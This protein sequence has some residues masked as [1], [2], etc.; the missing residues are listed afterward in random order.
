MKKQIAKFSLF[1]ICCISI[2]SACNSSQNQSQ[3]L[4][5]KSSIPAETP[6]MGWNSWNCFAF[7]TNEEVVKANADYMAKHLKEF[8]WKYIVVDMGWYYPLEMSTN[9]GHRV[10]PPHTID[11]FGRLMPDVEKY[12]S[13]KGGKGFK[14]LADYVHSKGLKFGIHIM[15]GVPWDAVE[16][17]MPVKSSDALPKDFAIHENLCEWN[18]SMKGVDATKP[19]GQEYYNSLFELYAEWEI[20]YIKV[21]DISRPYRQSE[22]EMIRKAID[23]CGRD[24]V[25][26][27]SPGATPLSAA[28]HVSKH[29]QLWRISNDF[30]DHWKFVKRQ[31]GYAQQWYP[32]IQSGSW[33]DLDMLPLGKLRVSG[34][35]EWVAGL[36][37]DKY[38]NIANQFTRF[39]KDEQ[40]TVMTLW[41]IFRSPLMF[42]GN[43][44]ENDEFTL[45]LLTNREVLQVNQHSK[46]NKEISFEND[47]SIWIADDVNESGKYLAIINTSDEER[48]IKIKLTDL[49][50]SQKVEVRDLWENTGKGSTEKTI[51]IKIPAH[52][53]ILYSLK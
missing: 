34:A 11:E 9:D 24:I 28:D 6:P 19:G 49:G 14:P 22:I 2:I 38:E 5:N 17:D 31:L 47:I 29:A 51:E 41:A 23:N 35:D 37:E 1:L 15:R 13:S 18:K 26:S 43:L 45:S 21:D 3:K 50:I 32:H 7:E 48:I 20:D 16:K 42:G 53:S 27:L 44:P 25:L 33:P 40:K 36:L 39:T 52:G 30:W 4:K 8:G 46:N 12:P 10:N